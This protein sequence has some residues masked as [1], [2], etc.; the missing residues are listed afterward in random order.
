M[1]KHIYNSFIA[2]VLLATFTACGSD[3][4][5]STTTAPSPINKITFSGVAIDGY[6]RNASVCLDTNINGTCD[7]GEPTTETHLDG[8]FTFNDVEVD[9]DMLMPIIVTGGYD[10]ATGK[11]FTGILRNIVN[12]KD[13]KSASALTIT[14]LSDLAAISFLASPD[15]SKTALET[16]KSNTA[17]SLGLSV[18]QFDSDPMQDKEVFAKVQ[19]VQQIKELL[20][21]SAGKAT[22]IADGS[23]AEDS[24]EVNIVKA[25]ASSMQSG[26][27]LTPIDAI[28]KLEEL[29]TT[30]T[31]P[32]NEK[33]FISS[34]VT[35]IKN[36]LESMVIDSS[37]N[38]SDLNQEQSNLE[39]VV[40]T[41]SS[42]IENAT[43]TSTIVVVT[44]ST[45]LV[46]SIPTPPTPPTL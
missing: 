25:I 18:T 41:A 19:E 15:K 4:E 36:A 32:A 13:I 35:E 31:I 2:S 27:T 43:S 44:D 8:T 37:V 22:G 40:A 26:S 9:D 38:I 12:T 11:V 30:V 34:Q 1:R 3:G 20:L 10:T 6:I 29:D 28:T 5:E 45:P 7:A 39:E 23:N 42:N 17:S 46:T 14:P 24:L 16:I 21:T 33:E